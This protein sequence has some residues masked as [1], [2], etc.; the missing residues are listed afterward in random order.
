M[1]RALTLA[2]VHFEVVIVYISGTFYNHAV[3]TCN[4]THKGELQEVLRGSYTLHYCTLRYG[5]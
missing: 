3:G 1:L 2:S 5:I 4:Q